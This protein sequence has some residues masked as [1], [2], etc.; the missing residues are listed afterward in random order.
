MPQRRKIPRAHPH[1]GS[2]GRVRA[3]LRLGG[4]DHYCGDWGT[5]EAR[6][7]E[8]RLVGEWLARQGVP[9]PRD[10]GSIAEL[11]AAFKVHAD[12]WYRQEN[13]RQTGEWYNLRTVSRIL[14]EL[15][16]DTPAAAFDQDCLAAV[17]ARFLAERTERGEA[18][19]RNHINEQVQ[20]VRRIFRWG[21]GKKFVPAAVVAELQTLPPLLEGRTTAP[22]PE[23]TVDVPDAIVDATLPFLGT[24]I[25]GMVQLQRLTGMRPGEVTK[26]QAADLKR[27]AD[28]DGVCWLYEPAKHKTK[29]L[30]KRRRIWFGPRAQALLQPFIDQA[31]DGYLFPPTVQR[32]GAR[33]Q[34]HYR[35][36]SYQG[37]VKEGCARALLDEAASKVFAKHQLRSWSP[38]QLRHSRLTEVSLTEG[39]L[40]SQATG[41]HSRLDTTAIYIHFQDELARKAARNSG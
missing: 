35:V 38:N 34:G 30:G 8:E 3:R 18:W 16:G 14:N 12:A 17:R 29:R 11:L 2:D 7:E 26:L 5:S 39:L 37:R 28:P 24:S 4:V 10:G 1:T 32:A 15:Y 22:E 21:A 36:D 13:G 9:K 25:A 6:R 33:Q 31:G 23:A 19:A 41:G 20:R 27:D 40:E